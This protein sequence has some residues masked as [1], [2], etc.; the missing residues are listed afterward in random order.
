MHVPRTIIHQK[1]IWL[2]LLYIWLPAARRPHSHS[3][4]TATGVGV[5]HACLVL[6]NSTLGLSNFNL[7][8][9]I[10]AGDGIVFQMQ[11]PTNEKGWQWCNYVT[12]YFTCKG[13]YAYGLQAFC[14]DDW[15][16]IMTSSKFCSSTNDY[17][18][19]NVTQLSRDITDRKCCLGWGMSLH[20]ARDVSLKRS[21]PTSGKRCI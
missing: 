7:Q 2:P 5:L 10:A 9:S 1:N 4:H 12:A 3:A 15:H 16:F 6:Q 8:G 20:W 21:K 17:T 11:M 13:H 18:T 19:Y 14:N